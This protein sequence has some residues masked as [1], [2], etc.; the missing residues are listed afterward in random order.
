MCVEVVPDRRFIDEGRLQSSGLDILH[1]GFHCID[2]FGSPSVAECD[3][4]DQLI[5]VRRF[6][7]GRANP[8]LSR[9]GKQLVAADSAE[10]NTLLDQAGSFRRKVM[11]QESHE[12]ADF[13]CRAVPVFL[14]KRVDGQGMDAEF[15][16]EGNHLSDG[17]DPFAMASDAG[18]SPEFRP[19]TVAVHDDRDMFRQQF[20]FQLGG[21]F[22][23]GQMVET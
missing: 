23:L 4:Q 6:F 16:T 3:G 9:W 18:E 22:A 15:Q 11:L 20:R 21:Q 1:H 13:L 12:R 5:Q 19:P 10:A 14:R 2:D 17:V 7:L 8:V